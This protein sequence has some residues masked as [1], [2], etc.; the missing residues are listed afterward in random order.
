MVGDKAD[1]VEEITFQ[2]WITIR[3]FREVIFKLFSWKVY[4]K[5]SFYF[6]LVIFIFAQSMGSGYVPAGHSGGNNGSC[7]PEGPKIGSQYYHEQD[8]GCV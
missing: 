7:E 1:H 4:E 8:H 5:V 6:E 2:V 3:K